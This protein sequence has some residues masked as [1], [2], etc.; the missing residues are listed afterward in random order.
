[1][2]ISGDFSG[3][4][5]DRRHYVLIHIYVYKCRSKVLKKILTYDSADHD[6]DDV[7]ASAGAKGLRR[8]YRNPPGECASGDRFAD[9]WEKPTTLLGSPVEWCSPPRFAQLVDNRKGAFAGHFRRG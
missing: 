7:Q 6:D 8:K 2:S 4:G 5:R 3:R 1:M 9:A